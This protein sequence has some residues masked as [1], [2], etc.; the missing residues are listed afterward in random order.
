MSQSEIGKLKD[1]E[2]EHFLSGKP[3]HLGASQRP[4]KPQPQP[5]LSVV[6]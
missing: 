4:P 3:L 6:P 1:Q 5:T 2:A